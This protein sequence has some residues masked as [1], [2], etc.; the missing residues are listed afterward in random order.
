MH[1]SQLIRTA[2]LA[3]ML[4]LAAACKYP[5][6]LEIERGDY[7]LVVEG[8]IQIGGKSTLTLSFSQPLDKKAYNPPA[9]KTTGY[10]EGE[11][12]T[13]VDGSAPISYTSQIY[14]IL[15]FDTSQLRPDQRYRLHFDAETTF[16]PDI[17][18]SSFYSDSQA[19]GFSFERRSFES[20]WL[21]VCPAPVIDDLSYS[22]DEAR[23][24]LDIGLSMHCQGSS[25]FRW[26]YSEDWEYHSDILSPYH[27]DEKTGTVLMG[28]G[29]V[30]YCWRHEDAT[31]ISIFSTE[32]QIEDRF[33]ELDFH[34]IPLADR[35]L[36]MLYRITLQLTALSE[37][38]YAYWRTVRQNTEEQ[39]SIFAPTPSALASNVHCTS[40]P[41]YQVLGYLNAAQVAQAQMYYDNSVA[42]YHQD[43]P[44]GYYEKLEMQVPI[45]PLSNLEAYRS[46]Y[47]PYRQIYEGIT[48]VPTHYMWA[49]AIC[50]DCRRSGGTTTKPADWPS[51]QE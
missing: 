16:Y 32:N 41:D 43:P 37:D 44:G 47:L 51:N 6:E 10:I 11:D 36:Q 9:I 34:H 3:A 12:G 1:T 21:T 7:P 15:E 5:Y 8:D 30:Y 46:G 48:T 35:R 28:G 24:E 33:E 27:F 13:R 20:D 17:L 49:A 25:H 23:D 39:G 18:S 42:K 26:T 22:L 40:H 19:G 29:D 50:I 31:H 14:N 45:D 2:A 38:A 4:L